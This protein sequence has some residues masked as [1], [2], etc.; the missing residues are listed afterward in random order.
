MPDAKSRKAR[1]P[2]KPARIDRV[3]LPVPGMHC[4]SCVAK[5]EAA[6]SGVRGV[7]A[8]AVHLP[9]R[10]AAAEYDPAQVTGEMLRRAVE[11][12]GYR[13]PT[14]TRTFEEA[15]EWALSGEAAERGRLALRT[16]V[17]A[18]LWAG[19]LLEGLLRLSPY[20]VWLLATP[21]QWWCGRHFH[22]GFVAS[23]RRKRADMNTLVSLS[24]WSAWLFSTWAIFF[25][26]MLPAGPRNHMLEAAAGLVV[27]VSLGRWLEALFKHRAG[28]ALN[29][30]LRRAPKTAIVLRGAPQAEHI[31][32]LAE[33]QRGERILVRPGE[34]VGLDGT[35]EEGN[36]TVDES[37][38]TGES[39]PVE[40]GRGSRVYGGTINKTG[41]L[42]VFV[43]AIGSQMALARIIEAVRRSQATKAPVQRLVDRVA[44]AFVPAVLGLAVVSAI[45][46][47]VWGPDPRATRAVT[48]FVSI[49]AVACPCALGLATPMAV[50]LG[51]GR[52]AESGI[53]LRNAESLEKVGRLDAVVFDKTGTLTEGR[54][55][56]VAIIPAPGVAEGELLR[57]AY[58]AESRSEHPF[59][60]AV[61]RAARARGLEP[62]ALQSFEALP[63]RGVH[64]SAGG[65]QVLCGSPAWLAQHGVRLPD[66]VRDRAAGAQSILVV[67]VDGLFRGALVLADK[68][69]PTAL[70]AVY[71]LKQQGMQ[72]VLASGD[73]AAAAHA[74]AEAVGISQVFAEVLPEDKLR[75]VKRLQEEG[76]RVAMV[77]EGFNDA[78][79]LSQ[80]DVGIALGSGADVAVEAAD[81]T[82]LGHDLN[83]VETA[84]A[85]SRRIRSIIR[86]NLV[87]AFLY[88]V[89]LL[90]VAAGALYPLTGK[91]LQ[92]HYAGAAMALSSL[93]VVLNSM[94]LRRF[95]T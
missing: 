29:R 90:P 52:A 27:L 23:L 39:M 81:V 60:E 84:I 2:E 76:K 7:K 15:A 16:A 75:I 57:D 65:H 79:A 31:V 44:G 41:A 40:K 63:G 35:V 71:R 74:I 64:A 9:S 55:E 95:G 73:R 20:T 43:T 12:A 67:A 17:G 94:R 45:A 54:P 56:I 77:G 49:L 14:V 91:M 26:E 47:A 72:V 8:A 86:Q 33:V 36:S 11:A 10:T 32:P 69:R 28:E 5:I 85:L 4:A 3:V 51:M 6:L 38:L 46:W 21:V 37:L 58:T 80:A 68:L 53:H 78:P 18:V 50:V 19:I 61:R 62:K 24:T 42:V 88:N 87:W 30:M 1:K 34:Q 89:L 25:P 92:P 82:L 59:A 83:H 22:E 13:V 93:S 70:D 66:V 48:A